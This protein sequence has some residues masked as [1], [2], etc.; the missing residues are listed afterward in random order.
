[1][2]HKYERECWSC[3]STEMENKGIYVACRSCGASWCALPQPAAPVSTLEHDNGLSPKHH[4]GIKTASPSGAT[5][6]RAAKARS[7]K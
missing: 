1:M 3:G 6:R 7:L 5:K 2:T 4:K